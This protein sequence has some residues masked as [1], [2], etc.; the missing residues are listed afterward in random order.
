MIST[1]LYALSLVAT[2]VLLTGCEQQVSYTEDVQPILFAS[3]L[4][5]HDQDSEGYLN[6]GFSLDSYEAV[7][8]GTKF[9][10]V[11]VPGSSES[12][13]LYLVVAHKTASEIHMPPHTDDAL[14]EGRG[15]SLT[16]E[17]IETLKLWIDQGALN[18]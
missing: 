7:M 1:R 5:C 4:S 10:A 8:K 17:Q 6:S 12:S 3:C 9:G 15:V 18:N 2:G 13:S 14:A 11:V 16:D